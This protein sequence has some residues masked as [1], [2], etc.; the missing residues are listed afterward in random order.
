MCDLVAAFRKASVEGIIGW[1]LMD[2]HVHPTLRG[3]ALVAE[4]IVGAMTNVSAAAR[5]QIAPLDV[6]ARRLGDN[7]YDQYV[8][9]LTMRALFE[10]PF[11]R[12]S[13]PEVGQRLNE[14]VTQ[15]ENSA[16][17]EIRTVLGE[18]RTGIAAG[19]NRPL[20]GLVARVLVR[21]KRYAEAL[22]LFQS[23]RQSVPEYTSLH[24]EYT[25]LA[26]ECKT[27]LHGA[28]TA[29]DGEVAAHAISQ[30]RV[31]LQRGFSESGHTENYLGR[32][33]QLRGEFAN[34][35]PFLEASRRKLSGLEQV[36]AE[37]ALVVSFVKTG[38]TEQA[39]RLAQSGA[40]RGGEYAPIYRNMLN[41]ITAQYA[42]KSAAAK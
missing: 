18:W 15:F 16:D 10:V 3:Q 31:L 33:C 9:N 42:T 28:L 4:S 40:D 23:A 34:A 13:N 14:A 8:V 41:Q 26:L 24:L 21:Q 29:A 20:T 37:R 35:I 2:D 7:P 6:Y 12:A 17:P 38:A 39:M 36:G 25:C 5:A 22:E 30:G 19:R 1:E 11:M 32:L 27:Q